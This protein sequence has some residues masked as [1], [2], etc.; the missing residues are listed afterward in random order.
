MSMKY[1]GYAPT[2]VSNGCNITMGD[3]LGLKSSI[4]QLLCT[5]K[6]KLIKIVSKL[7]YSFLI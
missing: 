4:K 5:K 3:F 2:E 6:I 1:G 7:I